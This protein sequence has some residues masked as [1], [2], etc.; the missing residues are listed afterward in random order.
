MT[1]TFTAVGPR[2]DLNGPPPVAPPHSLLNTPGVVVERDS[3]RWLNGVNIRAYPED[4]PSLWEPCSEDAYRTKTDGETGRIT[5]FDSFVCYL[6]I[7][8][9]SLGVYQDL[10][11]QAEAVLDATYSMPVE[12]AL[13]QGVFGSTNPFFGD[14]NL[15]ILG[16]GVVTPSTGLAYLENAIAATGRKGMIH[17]TPAIISALAAGGYNL[18]PDAFVEPRGLLTMNGTPIVSGDGYIGA[19][20]VSGTSPGAGQDWMFATGPVEVRLG[21]VAMTDV[22]QS[23]DRSDNILTFRAE[24]YVLASWDG[25][26]QAG[27]LVDWAP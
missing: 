9:S 25:A 14:T 8:C 5:T 26:L 6:P 12:E 11:G 20:P 2:L 22:S 24:R 10:Q 19:D 4:T 23:L 3:G 1:T 27:V 17:A 15:D 13:S 21:D 18:D 16:G 7:T